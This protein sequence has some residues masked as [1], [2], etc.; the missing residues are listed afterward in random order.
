MARWDYGRT[1]YGVAGS[2]K[3]VG[4]FTEMYHGRNLGLKPT[5]FR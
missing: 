2:S 5:Y 1:S 3:I 4:K